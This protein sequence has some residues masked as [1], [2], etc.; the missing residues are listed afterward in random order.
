MNDGENIEIQLLNIQIGCI[1]RLSRLRIGKS[2]HDISIVLGT[3]S[4]LIGRIE[5]AE[6]MSSWEKIY[7][8]SKS[9][10][11]NFCNLFELMDEEAL[12]AVID[13]SLAYEVKLTNDKLRYYV[14][15]KKQVFDLYKILVNK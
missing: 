7:S 4:T 6:N 9:L 11:T 3:N 12:L 10:N 15:L 8:M 5:R 14:S 13:E 2:Q 1:L